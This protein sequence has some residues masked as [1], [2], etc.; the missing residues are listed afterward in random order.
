MHFSV[1]FDHYSN[2][3]SILKSIFL[4]K[5]FDT[6]YFK[7]NNDNVRLDVSL[8][9]NGKLEQPLESRLELTCSSYSNRNDIEVLLFKDRVSSG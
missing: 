8:S 2:C 5:L 4:L 9:P 1:S 7:V 3:T 6:L